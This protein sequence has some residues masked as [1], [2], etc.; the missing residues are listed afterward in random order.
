M[1]QLVPY[2]NFPGN[3][4]EAMTF[5]QECLGGELSIMPFTGTPAAE[6]VP[7][8]AKDSVMHAIL[9]TGDLLLM[10]SDDPFQPVQDGTG[11]HLSLNCQSEEEIEQLF[12]RLGE[13]GNVTMPLAYQ[14]WG[15][16]FGMLTDRYGKSWMFNFDRVQN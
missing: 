13:G 6:Q 3:A 14:F 8:A 12:A 9:Q 5:Y 7:D 10:A 1:P 4:R 2:L 15:A 11:T 16:K